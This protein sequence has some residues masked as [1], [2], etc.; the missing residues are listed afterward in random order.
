MPKKVTPIVVANW[1]MN[2]L[3]LES[4]QFFKK[5]RYNINESLIGCEVV[6][7]PPFT[8]LRDFAEKIPNTGIKLGGQNCHHS[9]NGPYTGD[10]S[11]AML[12][13]MACDYVIVGHS[14]RRLG[15]NES[16]ELVQQKAQ[17]AHEAKLT[18]V[19]CVGET[20]YEH[21]KGLTE[22]IIR[23][24]LE[25]SIPETANE[26][27]TIIAYEPVWAIG[28]DKTPTAKEIEEAHKFIASVLKE[29]KQF[30]NAPRIIY[31][32]SV[33]ND[34]AKEILDTQ[35]VSGLLVGRSS[36]EFD[37]FWN[38]IQNAG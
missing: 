14:E 21:E 1:K 8:L 17:G 38:I 37:D 23:Q 28:T 18:V 6:L 20:T 7:C 15:H 12:Q 34:N 35:G 31:G 36:L 25:H 30:S 19:I 27:N 9:I 2:G 11:P 24:Q 26:K 16:S 4:M 29:M 13:D 32:G 5:L 10:I 3:L 22:D 33:S